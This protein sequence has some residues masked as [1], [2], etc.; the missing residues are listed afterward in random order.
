VNGKINQK[1]F[2]FVFYSLREIAQATAAVVSHGKEA[3][4]LKLHFEIF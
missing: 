1:W 2:I 3:E 4:N